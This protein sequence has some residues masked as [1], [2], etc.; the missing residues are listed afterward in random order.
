MD[1]L[2]E[3]NNSKKLKI[4][5]VDNKLNVVNYDEI[6]LITEERIILSKDKKS[7]CIK[8]SN[9][10]LLKLLESEML[11]SGSIKTIEL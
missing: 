8:G 10:V 9:L 7:I 5:Y 1:R 11:I 2:R 4:N 3:F 6:V